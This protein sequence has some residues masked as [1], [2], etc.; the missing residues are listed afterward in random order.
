ML[1]EV[2]RSV[3]GFKPAGDDVVKSCKP[4]LERVCRLSLELSVE[5]LQNRPKVLVDGRTGG[6][7][8]PTAG[9]ES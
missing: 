5:E 1:D 7:G 2:I 4:E 8:Q 9:R 3:S 6:E